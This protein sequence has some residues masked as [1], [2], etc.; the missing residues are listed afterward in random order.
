MGL[1]IKHSS[2]NFRIFYFHFVDGKFILLHA[3][4]KTT[5]KT[6]KSDLKVAAK[7]MDTYLKGS[8]KNE[9]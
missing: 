4:R 8:E 2:N 3:L 9:S 1:R 5:S 6:P 7:R